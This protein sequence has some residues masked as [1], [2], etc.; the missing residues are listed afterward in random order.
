MHLLHT[1]YC[2]NTRNQKKTHNPK[3]SKREFGFSS[4]PNSPPTLVQAHIQLF[5]AGLVP[6]A[7][8]CSTSCLQHVLMLQQSSQFAFKMGGLLLTRALVL[9]LGCFKF[10]CC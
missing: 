1:H 8:L 7:V 6:N 4:F 3:A 5:T 10:P 2:H 9:D